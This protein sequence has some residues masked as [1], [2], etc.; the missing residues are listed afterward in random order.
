MLVWYNFGCVLDP[1]CVIGLNS[2]P[3]GVQMG[4]GHLLDMN[5]KSCDFLAFSR[6]VL[7]AHLVFWDVLP[8][9]LYE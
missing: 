3:M 9:V 6:M 5:F 4:W 8:P 1:S 2:S 7:L